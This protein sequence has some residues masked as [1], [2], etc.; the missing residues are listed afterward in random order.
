MS[1]AETLTTATE[2]TAPSSD[3]APAPRRAGAGRRSRRSSSWSR[4]P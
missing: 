3:T 4:P 1:D 2:P